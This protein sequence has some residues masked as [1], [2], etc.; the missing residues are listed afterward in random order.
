MTFAV[1]VTLHVN[2]RTGTKFVTQNS[3][4]VHTASTYAQAT[5]IIEA[6][7]RSAVTGIKETYEIVNI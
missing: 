1:K 3:G 6:C 2:G 5:R 4:K 7:R